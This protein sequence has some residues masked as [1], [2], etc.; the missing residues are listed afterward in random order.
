VGIAFELGKHV[1]MLAR[2]AEIRVDGDQL[3]V[4]LSGLEATGAL[5]RSI[6]VPRAQVRSARAVED[7]WKELRGIRAPG[8]GF[9]SVIMLGTT[10]GKFGKDFCA[11]Y[12]H[13]PAVVIELEGSEFARLVIT[14][15]DAQR[16]VDELGV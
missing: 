7:G 9:P 13:D 5:H 6:K 2:V 15:P 8:T 12:K 3:E 1:S 14:T 16:V 4:E 11:V 10:R